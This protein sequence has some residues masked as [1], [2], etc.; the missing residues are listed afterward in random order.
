VLTLLTLSDRIIRVRAQELFSYA[1]YPVEFVMFDV[2]GF[3]R[4]L[5]YKPLL[6][7]PEVQAQ[8]RAPPVRMVADAPGVELDEIRETYD[9]RVTP[10][11]LDV[12]SGTIEA[13]TVGA[14]QMETIGVIDGRDAIVIE[15]V[16]RMAPDIAPDWPS[17][18]RGGTYRV[19]RSRARRRRCSTS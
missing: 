16:N 12:A 5:D 9:R 1:E 7:L 11:R 17:S 3:G 10:R 15:H 2:S 8:T 14:I 19:W 18:D 4:P 13:G 6:A